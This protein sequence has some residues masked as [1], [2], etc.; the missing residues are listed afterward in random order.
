MSTSAPRP[1]QRVRSASI[2]FR[3]ILSDDG[4]HVR[5]WTNDPDGAIDGPTVV[6]CNG[7]GTN[8]YLWPWLLDPD[9]G[10]RVVSWNH[11]GVGGSERPRDPKHVEI[12]HFVQDGLSVMD[13]F[14]IDSAVLMGWS[15]GVN[16]AFELTYRHPERVRG[17][18]AMCGVPGDTFATMLGP[19]HLPR[20]VAR[21]VTV[22]ACRVARHAGWALNPLARRLPVNASTVR[23]LGRTGFM[24]PVP[25]PEAAARGLKEF[26]TTPVDWYAHLAISTSRHPRVRLSRIDVPTMFVAATWDVLAGARDM[27]SASRRLVERGRQSTYAELRGSHFVQLEQPERVHALLLE[28][29]EQLA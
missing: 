4:T 26:V 27:A 28:F 15:M 25:D 12:E 7:L 19:L 1:E 18:F 22:N 9:C 20:L 2:A 3:D 6:L 16:T 23:L 14:G 8:A 11:R 21:T 5:A 24:F 13:H 10:V 17:I 29:L